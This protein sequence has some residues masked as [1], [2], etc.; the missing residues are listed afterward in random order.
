M[1]EFLTTNKGLSA[2]D[3]I[4]SQAKKK[5]V[6]ISPYVQI[7]E[8]LFRKLKDASEKG[9]EITLVYGKKEELNPDLK[10]QLSKLDNITVRF[11]KPLHAKC[12]FNE[13]QMVITSMNLYD[14]SEKNDEMGILLSIK[15]DEN[16]FNKAHSEAISI[17]NIAVKQKI[18][19]SSIEK[20]V[21]D[22]K[23]IAD[24]LKTITDSIRLTTQKEQ[25]HCISC[26]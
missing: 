15:E 13:T 22:A 2:I 17:V 6:L 24:S 7:P 18:K 20:F 8:K 5:L 21:K 3:D 25:G 16:L 26:N 14:F 11:H 4:I 9:V 12:F 1:A 19:D 23:P 10:K